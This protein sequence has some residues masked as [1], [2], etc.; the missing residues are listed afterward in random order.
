[1]QSSLTFV[2]FI[3]VQCS[4]KCELAKTEQ[5]MN[6]LE[7]DLADDVPE[8]S[9]L[10][11]RNLKLKLRGLA[12]TGRASDGSSTPGGPYTCIQSALV[13]RTKVGLTATHHRGPP[14]C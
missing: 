12:G 3:M 5:T 6:P 4:K 13:H 11:A 9:P 7:L 10:P 2:S 1:M 14:R 8:G